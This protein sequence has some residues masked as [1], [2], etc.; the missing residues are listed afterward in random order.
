MAILQVRSMDKDLYMALGRRAEL[1]NR[2]ISQEVIEI[3]KKY[4]ATPVS[5]MAAADDEALRL[6]GSW[7]DSRSEKEIA[8]AIRKDRTT[9]RS[10]G[11]F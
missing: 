9:R 11:E 7:D 4:L 3:I 6:A 5:R 10:H 2:S 1:E 8:G